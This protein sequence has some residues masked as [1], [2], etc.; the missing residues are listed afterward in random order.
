MDSDNKPCIGYYTGSKTYN[1][2]GFAKRR[3]CDNGENSSEKWDCE[4]VPAS[5]N[6]S[7]KFTVGNT[8]YVEG[9]NNTWQNSTVTEDGVKMKDCD[10]VLGFQTKSMDVV[11]L[12]SAK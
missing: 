2:V 3:L 8:V 4:I 9:N 5:G 12:K 6:T 1:G 11:F 10:A 7:S